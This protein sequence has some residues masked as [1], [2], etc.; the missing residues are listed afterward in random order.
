MGVDEGA[1]V[2]EWLGRSDLDGI[3]R[4]LAHPLFALDAAACERTRSRA[5]EGVEVLQGSV[6]HWGDQAGKGLWM[7]EVYG[8]VALRAEVP[9]LIIRRKRRLGL[10]RSRNGPF[11]I[12]EFDERMQVLGDD[13]WAAG[14]LGPDA[15]AWI[16]EHTRHPKWT[17]SLGGWHLSV[18]ASAPVLGADDLGLDAARL[19]WSFHQLVRPALP[20]GGTFAF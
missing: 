19:C 15:R 7:Y 6:R 4:D 8:A 3:P 10:P 9:E 18:H 20:G 2:D 16:A 11:P 12:E 1:G 14:L 5:V 17:I 13:G